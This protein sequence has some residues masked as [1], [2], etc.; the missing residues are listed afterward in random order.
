MGNVFETI[1]R[2]D[3]MFWFSALAGTFFFVLRVISMLVGASAGEGSMDIEHDASSANG[4]DSDSAFEFISINTLTA[5]FM[6]FGWVGLAAH[7]QFALSGALSLVLA[8]VS[9]MLCMMITMWLF[10]AAKKLGSKGSDFSIAK[11]LGV[12]ATVYQKI[13]SEGKGKIQL[14]VDGGMTREIDAVSEKHEEIESFATVKVK[15]V[16]DNNTVSVVKI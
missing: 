3:L 16:V 5:F 10:S 8:G 7:K 12:T 6:M 15:S 11:T 2:L 9:G 13:P 4:A 14:S 1:G